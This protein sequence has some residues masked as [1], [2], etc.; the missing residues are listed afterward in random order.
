MMSKGT[1]KETDMET[2][3]CPKHGIPLVIYKPGGIYEKEIKDEDGNVT[4]MEEI[5][6]E[7][8]ECSECKIEDEEKREQEKI[9]D[10]I[11]QLYLHPSQNLEISEKIEKK[12]SDPDKQK[13]LTS[14]S[15]NVFFSIDC[16]PSL[17]ISIY[18]L[19]QGFYSCICSFSS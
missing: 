6:I 4:G 13:M 8:E 12:L 16:G 1:K 18:C 5:E 2:K 19:V 14:S 3:L 10:L 17:N 15:S 7:L 11:D 9:D